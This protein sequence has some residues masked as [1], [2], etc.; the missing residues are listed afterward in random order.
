MFYITLSILDSPLPYNEAFGSVC[1]DTHLCVLQAIT[2]S[3]VLIQKDIIPFLCK[4]LS[5]ILQARRCSEVHVRYLKANDMHL[6]CVLQ[7]ITFSEVLIQ[8]DIIPFLCKELSSILQA[9]RCSEV[10]IQ[11]LK[12]LYAVNLGFPELSCVSI[13]LLF[14]IICL[15]LFLYLVLPP[16]RKDCSF[17][18][19]QTYY[20]W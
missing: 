11:Y 5:S 17:R 4:E 6:L 8:K 7:A 3:E 9:R 12:A 15:M 13:T 18:K 20:Q 14:I 10:L 2:F 16:S 1:N 19:F